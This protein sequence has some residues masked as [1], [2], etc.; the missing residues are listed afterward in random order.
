M[1]KINWLTTPYKAKNINGTPDNN[2]TLKI[3]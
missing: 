1:N 3:D 2:L